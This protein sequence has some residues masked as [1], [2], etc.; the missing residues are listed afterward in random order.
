MQYRK[1]HNLTTIAGPIYTAEKSVDK[2]ND[3]SYTYI[4][5]TIN[6]QMNPVLLMLLGRL[7]HHA[8]LKIM[9]FKVSFLGQNRISGRP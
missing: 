7:G 3:Q 4:P 6:T 9:K 8:I 5:T 2:E 1:E